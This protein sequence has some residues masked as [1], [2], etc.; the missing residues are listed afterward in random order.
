M[1]PNDG[2]SGRPVAG[3]EAVVVVAGYARILLL[4]FVGVMIV[5][6]GSKIWRRK[7][8]SIVLA[9]KKLQPIPGPKPLPVV[10]NAL[11]LDIN[12]LV[13]S[14]LAI[15]YNYRPIFSLTL[16]GKRETFVSS[17]ALCRELC[18]EQRFHKM[19]TKGLERLRPVTGDG[20]FTAY[21]DNHAWGVANRV[22]VPYFGTFRIRDMFDD[23]KDVAE[24]LCLKWARVESWTKLDL[25][26]EFTRLTLDTVALTCLDHRFNSFYHST[27]LPTFVQQIDFVLSEAA[28]TAT[29]PDWSIPLRVSRR[30]QWAKSVAYINKAC[31][32]MIDARREKGE[33]SSRKDVLSAM[34]FGKD[35]KTGEGLTDEQI[36]HNMLTFLSAGHE[37]TSATLALVCYFLCEHPEA[38][39]RARAEVDSVVGTGSLDIQHI[40]KL[41]YLEATLR[42]TLRL[43]PTAPAFFV[44][45]KRDEII[46][47]KYLVKQ[48]ESLCVA[49]EVLQRDPEAYGDDAAEFRPDRMLQ[50]GGFDSIDAFAWK[51][52]G[53]GSRGCIGRTFVWQESL[54]IL[55]LILQNFDIQKD[56]LKYKLKLRSDLSVK[57]DGFFLQARLRPGL[58]P[59]SLR[60]RLVGG[61]AKQPSIS[62]A[63]KE[64]TFNHVSGNL[65]GQPIS[66]L[67]GSNTGTCESLAL[68]LAAG[69]ERRGF[70]PHVVST[71]NS[72]AGK[73]PEEGCV[74]MIVASYN[75]LP[76]DNTAGMIKWLRVMAASPGSLSHVKYALFGCGNRNWG[77]TYQSIPQ[78]VGD[79]LESCGAVKVAVMGAADA[80]TSDMYS[81]LEKWSL[82]HLFPALYAI[83]GMAAPDGPFSQTLLPTVGP[84]SVVQSLPLRVRSLAN[85]G[86][87]PVKV[88]ESYQL[89]A[90]LETVPVKR[91]IEL[92][93]ALGLSYSPGDHLHILPQNDPILV[94]RVLQYFNLAD[95]SR[96][97]VGSIK[98][99]DVSDNTELTAAELFGSWVELRQP[100]TKQAVQALIQSLSESDI[101]ATTRGKDLAPLMISGGGPKT[102]VEILELPDLQLCLHS[103]LSIL[104]PIRPRTYSLSSAPSSK[105]RH[106][107]LTISV[108]RGGTASEYLASLTPGQ[109]VFARAQSNPRFLQQLSRQR[110]SRLIMI[111]VGSG[112]APFRGLIQ[113]AM[114]HRTASASGTPGWTLFYGCRGS[115]LDEL[116]ADELGA[117]EE[118][119]VIV[120]RRAYSQ[121]QGDKNIPR[122]VTG[123][124]QKHLLDVID[125]WQAGGLI[126][127]C[128]GKAIA[129]DIWA[130]LGPALLET[131]AG[132]KQNE[133]LC[134][135]RQRMA[136]EE[137]YVEEV[138]N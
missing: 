84:S 17:P 115:Q 120:L 44:T 66:I 20:L 32:D 50:P 126:R 112:I 129:D 77:D 73:L 7:Q 108:V 91:H 60:K 14:I 83:H 21:H 74:V 72:G 93:M 37:T 28:T 80:A 27:S 8:P 107:T 35:P 124:L 87:E 2:P 58:D 63:T 105:P 48:G 68:F 1:V 100:I 134:N 30:R 97:A 81:D 106:G 24:Q 62:S 54:I 10:G 102:A 137:R 125:C 43:V 12:D 79:L 90:N 52:F 82:E 111:C 39:S 49:L 40:Q 38:L 92:S 29:L 19:V 47:G 98:S 70:A 75:G 23:M 55:A 131:V 33:Q 118:A 94:Q 45:P 31:Q 95:D 41:P 18:D 88:I 78:L 5:I 13:G 133:Q 64:H 86:F 89:S 128:A 119:G 117:A 110:Q 6:I 4:P 34:V 123:A 101:G 46:G 42:E 104:A 122:Y 56:D 22:L 16:L 11:L 51:P 59:T 53:N 127:V 114:F 71:M 85:K 76:S 121:E 57:L 67:H 26:K 99:L 113:E 103:F 116:Y 130:L 132:G 136:E 96:I 65:S 135:W 109:V 9:S 61:R 138:F 25:S 36:I 3:W 15:A 69:A